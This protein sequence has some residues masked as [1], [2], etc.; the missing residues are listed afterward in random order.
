VGA[1][2]PIDLLPE[3]ASLVLKAPGLFAVSA[4]SGDIDGS[5]DPG[6]GL[7]FHD[8]RFLRRLTL[9][10][11][12]R[13]LSGAEV[14]QDGRRAE[15]RAAAACGLQIM[16]TRRLSYDLVESIT[17]ENPTPVSLRVQVE[18]DIACGFEHV[19]DLRASERSPLGSVSC[20]WQGNHMAFAYAGADGRIRTTTISCSPEPEDHRP[21]GP[22]YQVHLDAFAT[23]QLELRVRVSDVGSGDLEVIP[24]APA[25]VPP[26]RGTQVETSHEGFNAVLQQAFDDLQM[27][28]T[29]QQGQ[30]FFAAG[31]P[32]FVALFGRD[33]LIT[34]FEML[35]YQPGFARDSLRLLARY[36][37]QVYDIWRD[38]EPGKI[39]HEVRTGERAIVA[40]VP[41]SRY[42]GSIDA[43]PLFIVLLAEYLDWT[44][45]GQFWTE[46]RS[47]VE[48]ALQWLDAA[49][50]DGD[51]FIEYRRRSPGGLENQGWKDSWNAIPH[52]DGSPAAVPIALVEVQGYAY[53]ARLA[54]AR[55]Y[56]RDGDERTATS[57]ERRAS[58]LRRQVFA[59]YW[60]PSRG[61]FALALDGVHEQVAT[62]S[63]NVG[64]LLW[65]GIADRRRAARVARTLMSPEMFSGWG[66]RTIASDELA[67][68]PAD[69]QVGA[70][71]PHD[72]AII[73][74]GLKRYGFE[75]AA[76]R[77]FSALVEAA[78]ARPDRRLPELFGGH[79][80]QAGSGP[81]RYPEA[82]VPQAWAAA[83]LPYA[84]QSLLGLQP[85]AAAGT[86]RIVRPRLP[87]WLDRV[88]LRDLR[89]ADRTADIE[90]WRDGRSTR[91][92]ALRQDA[93]LRI[94]T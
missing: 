29:R 72:N 74:A 14:R 93:G 46:M 63:S 43:T 71:W 34:A 88:V 51:G 89:V 41:H 70:V 4:A 30:S 69:Y 12:G 87:R 68:D 20:R 64:H 9:S 92:R 5:L 8:T 80:R 50:R 54:A 62:V 55:L 79:T 91:V 36:Q 57:L 75:A 82:C 17:I 78:L 73:L 49:D 59:S 25:S 67:Y 19:F 33:S 22:S 6:H 86:L 37:G 28:A 61:I 90:W 83:A 76:E 66:I 77:V 81:R 48:R 1:S 56:R 84:L 53:A 27:L 40:D 13:R 39:P 2:A 21:H 11:N 52:R 26:V 24:P 35:A 94:V 3:P 65:S 60:M 42:Y 45:D 44:D 23:W 10:I 7:Y 47:H 31:V 32:W 16:R 18:V 58:R 38:E 85:D 15:L